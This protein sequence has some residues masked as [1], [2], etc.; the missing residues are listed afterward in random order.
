ME[1]DAQFLTAEMP[2]SCTCKR[3]LFR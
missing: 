2:I 3:S 1:D